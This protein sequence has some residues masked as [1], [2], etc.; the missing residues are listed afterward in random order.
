MK[1][2][3][4]AIPRGEQL[5]PADW[6]PLREP[7]PLAAQCMALPLGL[8]AGAGVVALW[9][10]RVPFYH[11]ERSPM[12]YFVA[13]VLL[14]FPA[15]EFLHVLAH[16]KKGRASV[17]GIWPAKLICY[18][19]YQGPLSRA[20]F[21]AILLAPFIGLTLLPLVVAWITG[22]ANML[23]MYISTVNAMGSCMDLLGVGLLL[24]QVPKCGIVQ[25]A[26]YQTFWRYEN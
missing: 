14:L 6:K 24:R 19:V 12:A 4:G 8:V 7:G 21:T 23:A 1:F 13:A 26:G 9:L 25:N 15:H 16:P 5:P 17:I 18:A 22:Q 10:W 3:F 11:M 20:R 2:C